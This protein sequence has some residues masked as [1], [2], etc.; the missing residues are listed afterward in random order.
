MDF[1]FSHI[2]EEN[3]NKL[4]NRVKDIAG[5]TFEQFSNYYSGADNGFGI[6]I[7]RVWKYSTPI[8]LE[9][10]RNSLSNFSPPQNFRYLHTSQATNLKFA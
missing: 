4:W 7:N 10:L 8:S 5:V 3:T 2:V 6:F 9:L 1:S